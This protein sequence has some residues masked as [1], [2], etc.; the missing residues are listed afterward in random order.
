M[1]TDLTDN[2]LAQASVIGSMLIDERCIPGVVAHVNEGDFTGE[3]RTVFRAIMELFHEG[4][5]IDP[6]VVLHR[7]GDIADYRARMAEWMD[8]TPTA[9]N[10]VIYAK[11]LREQN[12]LNR[13]REVGMKLTGT[14]QL[15]EARE[16]L[17]EAAELAADKQSSRIF[18]MAEAMREFAD[19][20]SG[21]VSYL[22]WP[23]RELTDE[24]QTEPGDFVIVGGRPSTG[25]TALTIQCAFH[26]AK[27]CKV[28]YFSLETDRRKIT[29]RLVAHAARINKTRIRRNWMDDRDWEAYARSSSIEIIPRRLE[30]INASGMSVSEIRAYTVM[31]G[32]NIIVIDYL[33]L[34]EEPGRS[35]TETTTAISKKLHTMAQSSQVTVVAL[36]QL[37]RIDKQNPRYATMADLRESGQIEQDADTILMLNPMDPKKPVQGQNRLLRVEK[38]KEGELCDIELEFEGQYQTFK[39][40]P[41]TLA[42]HM[43]RADWQNPPPPPPPPEAEPGY[44]QTSWIDPF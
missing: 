42:E 29:D 15:S 10:A 1:M 30:L 4:A 31:R 35:A 11:A 39:K 43:G 8:N 41:V 21:E 6:V 14:V 22:S 40:A 17:E 19:R 5:A 36:S 38:N 7:L 25:K 12:I 9:R 27:T 18:T 23:I 33:Q 28:G 34:I 32:Y 2:T 20:H 37:S 16:L 13:I 24:L 44:V 26:W 3:Y